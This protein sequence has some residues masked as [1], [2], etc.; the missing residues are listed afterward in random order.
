RSLVEQREHEAFDAGADG[1]PEGSIVW[2]KDHPTEIV[3]KRL[4]DEEG[5]A[6]HWNVTPLLERCIEI[7]TYGGSCT[8]D[9][10]RAKA[11]ENPKAVY[12]LRVEGP[13]PRI[14]HP[15]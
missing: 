2:L 3:V 1:H 8:E 14:V 4:L 5:H 6:S 7:S 11:W 10:N 12:C 13:L 15:S 9:D